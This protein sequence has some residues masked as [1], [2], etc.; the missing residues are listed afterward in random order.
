MAMSLISGAYFLLIDFWKVQV[1]AA[2]AILKIV[3]VKTFE[4][5]IPLPSVASQM[6]LT[7]HVHAPKV[8]VELDC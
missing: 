2:K 3:N 4:G 6:R 8:G 7:H 1:L 5:S